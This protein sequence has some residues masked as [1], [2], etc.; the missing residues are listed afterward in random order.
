MQASRLDEALSRETVGLCE[1]AL[2]QDAEQLLCVFQTAQEPERQRMLPTTPARRSE[3]WVSACTLLGR[4]VAADP[5]IQLV[6]L[7]GIAQ[8]MD[9]TGERE[10]VLLVLAFVP[11]GEA[12]WAYSR[13]EADA[14]GQWLYSDHV[15]AEWPLS[16]LTP[17]LDAFMAGLG[18]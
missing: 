4:L 14:V 17:L 2:G 9:A 3:D 8:I 13:W 18:K 16:W 12:V 5:T 15:H 1:A 10:T 7:G 11:T 6:H